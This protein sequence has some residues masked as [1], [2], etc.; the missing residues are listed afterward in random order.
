[1]KRNVVRCVI[2][3]QVVIAVCGALHSI[4]GAAEPSSI[5]IGLETFS[6]PEGTE[7]FVAAL[8]PTGIAAAATP[9]D[10][11]ILVNTS[12]SQVGDYRVKSI[13]ALKATLAALPTD[14]RVQLMAVDLDAIPLSKNFVAAG[15]AEMGAA[16]A[17]LDARV[18]LGAT[19]MEKALRTVATAFP[20]DGSRPRA[21]LYIGDGGSR[22]NLLG[23][24]SFAKL[25]GALAD[26][27]IPVS[28]YVVGARVDRQLPAALAV[29]TGGTVVFDTDA[30]T[31]QAAG[32]GL[33][34]A[35]NTNVW[36]PTAVVWPAEVTEAL[37]KRLPPLRDDRATIA[38]GVFKGKGPFALQVTADSVG[39]PIKLG[40]ELSPKQSDDGNSYLKS[41]VE[42]AKTDGGITLPLLGAASLDEARQMVQG[43][44][45]NIASLAQQALSSGD[46]A[47]ASQ[48]VDEALRQDPNDPEAI[49][50]QGALAK[51]QAGGAAAPPAPPAPAAAIPAAAPPAAAAPPPPR[52]DLNLTGPDSIEPPPGTLAEG[53]AHDRR[54]IAQMIRTEMQNTV[55]QARSL[56]STD[57]DQAAQQLKLML[58]K[59]RRTAELDPEVR[60]QLVDVLETA[61]REAA[62]Q[63]VEFE[64][65]K[66]RRLE[67]IAAGKEQALIANE[68][69]RKQLKVK[70]LM[71]RFNSL[72]QEG[73]WGLA[74]TVA[75][76][77]Q[78]ILPT[79]S[80]PM[81]ADWY[82]SLKGNYEQNMVLRRQRQRAV[83]ETLYQVERSHI[84]FPDDP[85]IVYTDPEIWQQLSARRKERYSSMDLSKQGTSEKKI[86]DALKS[87]TQLEFIETP[88][89]DVID[90]LKDYHGIEIQLDN[91]A[92]SDVGIGSDTPVT[93]NLKGITLRS[94]MRL[95]LR[96][97]NLT[98]IIKD[99]VL[100]ITTPEEA[101]TQLSTKVY[102][103][104]DLVIPVQ[105]PMM[106]GMGGMGGGMGGMGGGG[107]GG[108]GGGGMGGM[109]GGGMGG[110]GGGM[111]GM[112]GGGGM[113][114]V[115]DLLK[116]IPPGGFQAFA[117][118]DD[119]S[120]PVKADA[121]LP[122]TS[123]APTAKAATPATTDKRPAKIEVDVGKD[124]KPDA[125]WEQYFSTTEPQ[126]VAVRDA[127]RQ[128][129]GEQNF[130]Q[131]IALIG[132]ALRHRQGQPWM[133]EAMA[134]ALDAAG[135]PKAEIER[136][137]MSAVDFVESTAD[138]MYIGAYLAHIG[139]NERALQVYRQAAAIDPIRPEPYMLGLRTA[140]ALNSVDGLKWASLGIL[141]QAWPKQQSDVWQAGLG[142]AREVLDTLRA[143]K[144]TAEA[145][146]FEAALDQAVARDCVAIV[147]WTGD[148]DVDV[149][150]EEPSGSVCSL[151]SPRTTS[152]GVLLGDAITQTGRDS[153]GGHSEVYV[154]P[155]GFDGTYKLLARRVWGNVTTGKVNVEV[156]THYRTANAIDVRKK[157]A[158]EKDEAVV[159]FDLINGRRK[160]PLREQQVANAA[161]G[162]L[163]MNR[164]ILAQQMNASVD[165]SVLR[166]LALSRAN[167]GNGAGQNANAF[168]FHGAVGYQPVIITLPEGANLI[169]TAVIS[170]D[171]RYVRVTALPLFSGIGQVHTFNTSTGD[172]GTTGGGTGGQ[173]FSGTS[174]GGGGGFGG[175]GGGGLGGICFG[176][177][178]CNIDR[179]PGALFPYRGEHGAVVVVS[180]QAGSPG[181]KAGLC[182]GDVIYRYEGE[183][184]PVGD[185]INLLRDK[186][187]PLKLQGNVTRTIGILREG[188]ELEL[189]V[190]WPTWNWDK[191]S[192]EIRDLPERSNDK[193]A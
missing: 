57:P 114:N 99:E 17:A 20:N 125:V 38:L 186:V 124:A 15:S 55:A 172:G 95:M 72:M 122:A 150:V 113:F 110:M 148:A 71:A 74:E 154:C 41:L 87:P 73:R 75:N 144:K 67:N 128:L 146:A 7:Y 8:K 158:L 50:L 80:V 66:Q 88:L 51:R 10:V 25:T 138:L 106:S 16:L 175:G 174:G 149:L 140:R 34:A 94:A 164:Q 156:M 123:N 11:I 190:T 12:A 3:S 47:A 157:I 6:G 61:L 97:L 45:R 104:A 170:A 127:V 22:A 52:A 85:P 44:V 161:G 64:L 86:Q 60:D 116:K 43:G 90:Y 180:T 187:I 46:V 24:A 193:A 65:A 139:L 49:A 33:A 163:A 13:E 69:I 178:F 14:D 103:V 81:Q 5:P 21:V 84:P 105:T 167:S 176:G 18:P 102:P 177:L 54:V 155:R 132:A 184:L 115:Q 48:L 32:Q 26:L 58:E 173:G 1:M 130:E 189:R 35:A 98:Y 63:K 31:G 165:P 131:V 100:L 36:W 171:R 77:A 19:D 111:G 76:E 119:L 192:G 39:G 160:E 107:M 137:V 152:G 136:A 162:M 191:P 166:A 91:K 126:P 2:L 153:F 112:G 56:M 29:Q 141:S 145:D 96:E 101:E 117:V 28:S 89:S 92:L 133:Y 182:V 169:A 188:V 108:M 134:L 37:P 142:V 23:A 83:L 9:R 59:V 168:N 70:E 40:F 147:T 181:Q 93:K 135:R 62:R 183:M 120:V 151:R 68:L 159:S 129:M 143:E 30:M 82:A 109:G 42:A 53:F 179:A 118:Q 78:I 121:V 185:T 27:R 79:S 4:A